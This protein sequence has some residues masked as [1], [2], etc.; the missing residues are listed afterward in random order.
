M[1]PFQHTRNPLRRF[2]AYDGQHQSN[3]SATLNS[4][5]GRCKLAQPLAGKNISFTYER[6]YLPTDLSCMVHSCYKVGVWWKYDLIMIFIFILWNHVRKEEMSGN[7]HNDIG[8]Q[9]HTE[10]KAWPV[11]ESEA[12]SIYQCHRQVFVKWK[13]LS[14]SDCSCLKFAMST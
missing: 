4:A 5:G 3:P 2:L 9:V 6:C 7:W 14:L 1:R 8:M 11:P 12:G 10:D 13:L